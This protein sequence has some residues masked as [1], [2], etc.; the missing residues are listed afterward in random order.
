MPRTKDCSLRWCYQALAERQ[1]RLVS[2][3]WKYARNTPV[4]HVII[5]IMVPGARMTQTSRSSRARFLMQSP[6]CKIIDP[7]PHMAAQR[8]FKALGRTLR[9]RK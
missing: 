3:F 8:V 9:G 5:Q 1:L 7:L 4:L 2:Y 6:A